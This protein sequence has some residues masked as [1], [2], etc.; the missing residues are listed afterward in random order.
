MKDFDLNHA[1]NI[2]T[3]KLQEWLKTL[4]AMLPNFFVA[5]LVLVGFFLLARLIR[6]LVNKLLGKVSDN[7]EVNKLFSNL[8]YFVVIGIGLFI[9]LST[10][11][12]SKAVTSLLAGA[13]ILGLALG[14]VF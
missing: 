12:L 14:F 11:N 3:E 9:A 1:I 7:Y 13:G 10:L 6:N 4:I 5:V 8:A 2:V